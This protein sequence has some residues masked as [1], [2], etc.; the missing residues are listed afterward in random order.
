MKDQKPLVRQ[1]TMLTRLSTRHYGMTLQ[2]LAQELDVTERTIRR[3]IGALQEAGF[4]LEAETMPQE[5]HGVKRWRLLLGNG[6]QAGPPMHFNFD[7]IAAL[8]MGQQFLEPLAGTCFGDGMRHAIRKIRAS[9][10]DS[11]LNY[12]QKLAQSVHR[13]TFG[14]GDYAQKA[15]V[16]DTLMTSIEDRQILSIT[17]QSLNSTEPVTYQIYPYGLVSHR[18]ALYVVAYAPDHQELRHYK[19]DRIESADLWEMKFPR[20]AEFDLEEHLSGTLGIYRTNGEPRRIRLRF[21]PGLSRHIQEHHWHESQ[22]LSVQPDGGLLLELRLSA[23]EELKTWVLGFG[24]DVEV[25]EPEDLKQ[26]VVNELQRAMRKYQ[27]RQP[28]DN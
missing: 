14:S 10:S 9:L 2:E 20:P 26:E 28:S 5:E 12:L 23:V 21:A 13:T 15:E 7:E 4:P 27:S 1:W 3:D 24:A 16:I 18:E 25:L 8:A 19:V 6:Y 11:A 22:Q 17:Y